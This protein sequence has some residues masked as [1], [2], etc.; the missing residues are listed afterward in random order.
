MPGCLQDIALNPS[1]PA[2][3]QTPTFKKVLTQPLLL[4]PITQIPMAKSWILCEPAGPDYCSGQLK[5]DPDV[6]GIGIVCATYSITLMAVL[7]SWLLW[8]YVIVR[9]VDTL[10]L[11]NSMES[12][13]SPEPKKYQ[14]LL[15]C[16]FMLADI[17]WANLLAVTISSIKL[18]RADT[19]TSLYHV[20][21]ARRLANLNMLGHGAALIFDTRKPANWKL[22]MTL[23]TLTLGPYFYWTALAIKEFKEEWSSVAPMCFYNISCVPYTYEFW[24][25]LDIPWTFLGYVWL[26]LECTGKIDRKLR[27]LDDW[28]M[29]GLTTSKDDILELW[30]KFSLSN[31]VTT[32]SAVGKK[33]VFFFASLI[34]SLTITYFDW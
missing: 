9:N 25:Q 7:V 24:M 23:L 28:T 14:S 20:F 5:G 6:A 17:Q 15:K 19:E 11:K 13:I 3:H 21:I 34:I 1:S 30:R 12:E 31:P 29:E 16:A 32:L 26:Y 18:I 22:R 33:L 27:D 8:Y 4:R 2:L 10:G